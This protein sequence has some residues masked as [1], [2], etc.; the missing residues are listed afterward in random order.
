MIR[1]SADRLVTICR[2]AALPSDDEGG[3]EVN[4]GAW[5]AFARKPWGAK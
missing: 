3:V 2:C 5:R 4:K 1:G